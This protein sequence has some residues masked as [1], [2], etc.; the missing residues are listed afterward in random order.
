MDKNL[1]AKANSKKP[2]NTF[3]VLSQPPDLGIELSQLGN[4]ANNVKG[5]AKA[6]E[7]PNILTTGATPPVLADATKAVPT[8]GNVQEKDTIANANA[9]KKIP[10]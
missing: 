4:I 10:K 1:K 7:K 5:N 9:I 8:I 2:K 6:I 3:T